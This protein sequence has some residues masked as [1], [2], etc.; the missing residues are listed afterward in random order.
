MRRSL[1]A[2]LLLLFCPA[3]AAFGA[4]QIDI[5]APTDNLVTKVAT[6]D[7]VATVTNANGALT[8]SVGNITATNVGD[9]YTASNVPLANGPN[10][11]TVT[12][13]D[14]DGPV[15][16]D[17]HVKRLP[18]AV[19]DAPDD[20][21]VAGLQFTTPLSSVDVSGHVEDNE[22]NG[23]IELSAGFFAFPATLTADPNDPTRF[24]FTGTVPN[25]SEGDTAIRAFYTDAHNNTDA[26]DPLTVT[27]TRVCTTKTD[28]TVPGDPND[29]N[30]S[31]NYFVD[32]SDDLPDADPNDAKCDIRKEVRTIPSDPNDPNAPFEPPAVFGHC[33]LR[34]A[35]EQANAHPGPDTISIL[36]A[37]KI[38]LTR[39]GGHEDAADRGDLDIQDDTRIVGISRDAIVIDGRK[40]GDRVFDV[41]SGK[42]LELVNVTVQF[43]Q[44]PKPDKNDPNTIERGGCIRSQGRLDVR[45][46]A[47][48]NCTSGDAGGAVSLEDG[49]SAMAC[50]IVARSK[51]KTDGGAIASDGVPLTIQNSTLA[52]NSASGSG[53][54]ISM[55]GGESA[56]ALELRNDTLSQN[57]AKVAGGALDLGG[58]VE[59]TINNLTFANNSAKTGTSISTT[60]GATVTISNS[61]LGDKSKKACDPG[62]PV[63]STGGNVELGDT[64]NLQAPPTD[65]PG[66]DPQLESLATNNGTT[67]AHRLKDTSPAIDHAGVQTPCEPLDQRE[68]SRGDWPGNDPNLGVNANPKWCDC[69]SLELRTA[70]P[71]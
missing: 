7:V 38:V 65:L 8:V 3:A 41:R 43:G 49:N 44:T 53:G 68:V 35:I 13:T 27:R 5:T 57:K 24:N 52:I 59:A 28:F 71:Q 34:A 29:P 30:A 10:T 31:Q 32:R 61:I 19:I 2:L 58:L 51:A 26:S 33:T 17:V 63:V 55:G 48:L 12:A 20:P 69:G 25:L 62:S 39:T 11:L 46:V 37:R 18:F 15:T 56:L 6:I 36:S 16:A 9:V 47:L 14:D 4:P 66:T 45:N 42:R 22:P 23:T 40:L 64:C 21:N 54:A 60:D 50:V 67:P 70:Q 1:C